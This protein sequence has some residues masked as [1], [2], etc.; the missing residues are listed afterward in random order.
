MCLIASFSSLAHGGWGWGW[1]VICRWLCLFRE[2][3][4]W[5]LEGRGFWWVLWLTSRV[6]LWEVWLGG[7]VPY[8]SAV[9]TASTWFPV[10]PA[11]SVDGIL[12]TGTIWQFNGHLIM[13]QTSCHS[14]RRSQ[15]NH[16][17][18]A[19]QNVLVMQPPSSPP[20]PHTLLSPT[21][22]KVSWDMGTSKLTFYF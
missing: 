7:G 10:G 3:L 8:V 20:P 22:H 12:T 13:N 6:S 19:N 16:L 5:G 15:L 2:H 18:K 4:L 14:T 11:L 9:M 1:G 17:I 21:G